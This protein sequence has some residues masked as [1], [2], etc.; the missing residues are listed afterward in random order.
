METRKLFAL[1][2][3]AASFALSGCPVV[4]VGAG[5]AGG[6]AISKDSVKNNYDLPKNRV[7]G[8]GLAVLKEMGQVTSEDKKN[9]VLEGKIKETDVTVTVK[10]LTRKTVELKVKA[11]NQIKM[12]AVEV[13]Q[14][15]YNK[16]D[17]R[18]KKPWPF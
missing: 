6:Y 13:A 4:L 1:L 12:P 11:R 5:V 16:I 14:E 17:E 10:P 18:L 9:G 7:Y 3:I 8:S 15:V 2:V